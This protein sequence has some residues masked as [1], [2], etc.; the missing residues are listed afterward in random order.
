MLRS[1]LCGW[2][3]VG[4][5][6]GTADGMSDMARCSAAPAPPSLFPFPYRVL[7]PITGWACCAVDV[8]GA[9]AG[10]RVSQLL[11]EVVGPRTTWSCC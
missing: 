3:V 8:P 11:A 10:E 4:R 1:V 2:S 7:S 6:D 9:D 5:R